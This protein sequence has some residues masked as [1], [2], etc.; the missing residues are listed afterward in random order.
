MLLKP[1]RNFFEH[2]TYIFFTEQVYKL[3]A[4]ILS[5]VVF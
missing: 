5:V 3:F 4:D 1:N 2:S